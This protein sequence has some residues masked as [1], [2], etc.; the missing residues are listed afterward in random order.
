MQKISANDW[1]YDFKRRID[2]F[3]HLNNTKNYHQ[4]G[5]WFGGLLFPEAFLTATRQYVS[6]VNSWSLE[7]LELKVL[8]IYTY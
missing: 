4:Q 7:E 2:Q 6:M 8:L 3:T 1:L 5:V